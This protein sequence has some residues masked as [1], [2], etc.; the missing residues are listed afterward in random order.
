MLLDV[1]KRFRVRFYVKGVLPA[2]KGVEY[3][4]EYDGH[5]FRQAPIPLRL[6]DHTK[7]MRQMRDQLK[8]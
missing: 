3:K 4:I 7:V 2:V 5:E 6:E 1:L 8:R